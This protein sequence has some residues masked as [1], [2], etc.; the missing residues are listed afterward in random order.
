[1]PLIEPTRT[2]H[3]GNGYLMF[4]APMNVY[5]PGIDYNW[6]PTPQADYGQDVVSPTWGI[7]EFTAPVGTNGGLG[8]Y[9]V[10]RHPHHGVWTRYMHLETI[11]ATVGSTVAPGQVVG[12]LG[13]SGTTSA[14]LHFEVL[15]QAGYDYIKNWWRPYGRYPSGLSKQAVAAMFLDPAMWLKN[16]EQPAPPQ[17]SPDLHQKLTDAQQQIISSQT[18]SEAKPVLARLIARLKQLLP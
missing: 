18:P 8:N 14:H 16:S 3:L 17:A 10:I 9:L 1:M 12:K 11:L 6:G 15:N 2:D 5:H 4:F 7:V 13:D